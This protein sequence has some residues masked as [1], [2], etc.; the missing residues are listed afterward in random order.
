[1]AYAEECDAATDYCPRL[2]HYSNPIV[3][4][5]WFWTG[6]AVHDNAGLIRE[7]APLVTGYRDSQGL[8]FKNGFE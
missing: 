3:L 4:V 8:I 6:W 7:I 2:Q 5:Y 1:M